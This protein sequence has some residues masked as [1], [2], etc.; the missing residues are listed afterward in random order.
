MYAGKRTANT[1]GNALFCLLISSV[2]ETH[3]HSVNFIR[4]T[5]SPRYEVDF[6]N[7]ADSPQHTVL[8]QPHFWAKQSSPLCCSHH[9]HAKFPHGSKAIDI[10][11]FCLSETQN[12]AFLH[13]QTHVRRN[14]TRLCWGLSSKLGQHC[15]WCCANTCTSRG[16][17]ACWVTPAPKARPCS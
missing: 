4:I 3:F 8:L 17:A 1:Q 15:A 6:S 9:E 7:L 12:T 14:L 2:I 16:K 5:K 10:K 13:Q 11:S